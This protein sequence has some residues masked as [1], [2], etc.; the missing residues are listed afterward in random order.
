VATH[1]LRPKD[2]LGEDLWTLVEVL[3][4]PLVSV[5]CV[6]SLPSLLSQRGAFRLGLADGRIL[7]GRRVESTT[8]AE[9]IEDLSRLLDHRHFPRVLARRGCALLMEWVEGRPIAA[10][11]CHPDLFRRCGALQGALHSIPIA[12]IPARQHSQN[13]QA[14]LDEKIEVLVRHDAL[15]RRDGKEALEL[16]IADAPDF[17]AV[18]FSHGDFCLENMV[19]RPPGHVYVVDNESLL[20]G[21]YDYDLAR[22]WYRWPM[23]SSE[24]KAYFMGY[25]EYRSAV[26]FGAHFRHWAIIA[27]LD[28]ALFRVRNETR[29]V[30]VPIRRLKAL[31]RHAR[32][33]VSGRRASPL[34]AQVS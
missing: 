25:E 21:A 8:V 12:P 6:S 3:D 15:G 11:D 28:S 20:I 5:T 30:W 14:R 18:G 1:P 33:R 31:L 24:R 13:W 27:L 26:T 16:A 9:R 22:T 17:F 7:K 10:S 19:V 32:G 34:W 4:A 29:G 23:H 2:Q